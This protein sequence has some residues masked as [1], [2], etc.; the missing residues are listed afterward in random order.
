M[1]RRVAEGDPG[2]DDGARERD[3]D[4]ER[5]AALVLVHTPASAA[6][7]KNVV[8]ARRHRRARPERCL[9]GW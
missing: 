4:P 3:G 5:E 8:P 2:E 9:P 1:E 7:E 6:E